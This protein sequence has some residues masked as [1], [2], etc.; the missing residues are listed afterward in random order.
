M[1]LRYILN[2]IESEHFTQAL[3]RASALSWFAGRNDF[4][5]MNNFSKGEQP[6]RVDSNLEQS[7]RAIAEA[8]SALDNLI[9]FLPS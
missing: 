4:D 5:S 7:K 9:G 6:I 1:L 3:S 2:D 8:K